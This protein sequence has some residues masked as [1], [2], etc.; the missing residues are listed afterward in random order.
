M[1]GSEQIWF[2]IEARKVSCTP[3]FC[4]PFHGNAHVVVNALPNQKGI[5]THSRVHTHTLASNTLGTVRW[6]SE[7]GDTNIGMTKGAQYGVCMYASCM[8]MHIPIC[9][10]K[11]NA[12][13]Q[14]LLRPD[15]VKRTGS[16]RVMAFSFGVQ[17][18]ALP[19][20]GRRSLHFISAVKMLPSPEVFEALPPTPV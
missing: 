17:R 8:H 7:S 4:H 14:F 16:P 20:C 19:V 9:P 6:R 15:S 5:H 3:S 12:S 1:R 13:C 10:T 11:A 2:F 18:L